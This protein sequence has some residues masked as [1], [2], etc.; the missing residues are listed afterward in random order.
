MP[1]LAKRIEI[2][3]EDRAELER[4]AR[5]ATGQ[6]RMVERAEIVLSAAEGRSA[7]A[8]GRAGGVLDEHGPE[9]ACTL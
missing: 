1:A 8:I 7:A 6:V 2:S 3:V 4:I 5:S 9:V